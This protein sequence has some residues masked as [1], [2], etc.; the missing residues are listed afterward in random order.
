V[1]VEAAQ[2]LASARRGYLLE[3]FSKIG[4]FLMDTLLPLSLELA[5]QPDAR[6]KVRPGL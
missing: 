2:K 6:R 4:K 3:L 1:L 5:S